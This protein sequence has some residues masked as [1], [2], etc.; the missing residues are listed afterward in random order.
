VRQRRCAR[1]TE[2]LT[3]DAA[4]EEVAL[5]CGFANRHHFTRVFAAEMGC[6]PAEHRRRLRAWSPATRLA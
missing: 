1:A 6:G 3:G 5:R 4:I 2:L